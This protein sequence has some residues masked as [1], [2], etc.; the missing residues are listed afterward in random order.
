MRS[1]FDAATTTAFNL[2]GWYDKISE[3]NPLGEIMRVRYLGILATCSFVW[4][5]HCFGQKNQPLA[6]E[7]VGKLDFLAAQAKAAPP[8]TPL[9]VSFC[10]TLTKETKAMLVCEAVFRHTD[11]LTPAQLISW[12]NFFKSVL[13]SLNDH[14]L[15]DMDA[16]TALSMGAEAWDDVNTQKE[17]ESLEALDTKLPSPP[18][19]TSPTP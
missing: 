5:F 8:A 16:S 19:P 1:F 7:L 2:H 14:Q 9:K 10:A 6:N 15:G 4:N 12:T 17:F 3:E 13:R 18:T 11:K